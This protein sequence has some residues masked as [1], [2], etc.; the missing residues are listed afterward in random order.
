VPSG[1]GYHRMA[2]LRM[3]PVAPEPWGAR[4]RLT[5]PSGHRRECHDLLCVLMPA[6]NFPLG[7]PPSACCLLASRYRR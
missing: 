4:P 3:Q 6:D 5:L 1:E 2:Y 7:R